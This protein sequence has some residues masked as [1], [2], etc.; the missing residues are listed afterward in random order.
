MQL[1]RLRLHNLVKSAMIVIDVVAV[2]NLLVS[3]CCVLRKDILWQ[4][5][6]LSD[7][8]N[9][10]LNFIH[11]F[12]RLKNKMKNFNRTA[13]SWYL[14][15]QFGVIA[16]PMYSASVAF[17]QVKKI[18]IEMKR[19]EKSQCIFKVKIILFLISEI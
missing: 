8:T 2:R 11:I 14:R 9:P 5:S 4:L 1:W 12:I 6:L 10:V 13:I 7:P 17:L 16:C 3:F 19:N 15:K 18:N